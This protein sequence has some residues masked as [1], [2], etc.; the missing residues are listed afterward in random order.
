[1]R[2]SDWSSDVCSS[3]LP[4][5]MTHTGIGVAPH[6]SSCGEWGMLMNP[7][8][9]PGRSKSMS[10]NADDLRAMSRALRWLVTSVR[11]TPEKHRRAI[12]SHA[13]QGFRQRLAPPL[14]GQSRPL[15]V[16]HVVEH[17]GV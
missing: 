3:D 14:T 16:A 8:C 7:D 10:V 12:S 1:M 5:L 4:F 2:I 9:L 6:A 15:A 17:E 13:W 11:R